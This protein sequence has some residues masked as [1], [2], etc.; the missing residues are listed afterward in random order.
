MRLCRVVLLGIIALFARINASSDTQAATRNLAASEHGVSTDRSLR[1]GYIAKE[2]NEERVA[3]GG[4]KLLAAVKAVPGLD[5]VAASLKNKQLAPKEAFK[6]FVLDDVADNLFANPQFKNWLNYATEFR[7]ANPHANTGSVIDMLAAHYTDDVLVRII[8][9]AKKDPATQIRAA[10]FEDALVGKWVKDGQTPAYISS[11]F[12]RQVTPEEA[13][14]LLKYDM[15]TDNFFGSREYSAW[16]SYDNFFKSEN[17]NVPVKSLVDILT[18]H[19]DDQKLVEI[20]NAVQTNRLSKLRAANFEKSLIA[21]WMENEKT[22]TY[23]SNTLGREVTPDDAFTLLSLNKDVDNLFTHSEYD[24]WLKYAISFKKENPNVEADPVIETLMLNFRD[25]ALF[26]LIKKAEMTPA[27]EKKA[28]FIKN[29]LLDEWVETKVPPAY[30]I[31]KLATSEQDRKKLLK[32]YLDKIYS[33][34]LFTAKD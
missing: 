19:Y 4:D 33:S 11:M 9:I 32:T 1:S 26:E 13:F 10:Y 12:G 17:P 27:T 28:A 21:K 14:K 30:V 31:N 15:R 23:I 18:T 16:L 2:D 29:A 25:D 8:K 6:F 22:S 20:I 5:D 3:L 7:K 34:P 24:T